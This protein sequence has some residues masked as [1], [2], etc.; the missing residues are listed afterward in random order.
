MKLGVFLPTF[1]DSSAPALASAAAAVDAQLDG[2]FA[3]DH[4]WP[5]GS[6]TRPA[7]APLPVL[8][9]VATK[10]AN[11]VV[12]PLVARIGLVG[13]S[14][15]VEEF[16]TLAALAPGRVVA[17]LG[18]GDHLSIAE[19]DAYGLV[20]RDAAERRAMLAETAR[21]LASFAEVWIGAG[22]PDTNA[23]AREVGATLNLWD[24][25]PDEVAAANRAGPVSWAGP[26]RGDPVAALDALAA[27]GATWAVAGPGTDVAV[28]TRWRRENP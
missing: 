19:N 24:K 27:A 9:V 26:L 4:L 14:R 8:A 7:L 2:V 12:G 22:S 17:A 16:A 23:L 15:M 21:A 28:L 10:F 20:R 25:T 1:E 13:T 5:M 18:T 6:P 3:Y 11:L